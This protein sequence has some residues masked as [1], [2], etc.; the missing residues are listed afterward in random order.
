LAA[1]TGLT[2]KTLSRFLRELR[3]LGYLLA[4]KDGF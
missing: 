2:P 1:A 4:A 3:R